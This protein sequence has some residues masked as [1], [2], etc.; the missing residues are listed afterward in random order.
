MRVFSSTYLNKTPNS[1]MVFEGL[2]VFV[3]TVVAGYCLFVFGPLFLGRKSRQNRDTTQDLSIYIIEHQIVLIIGLVILGTL[4]SIYSLTRK[5]KQHIVYVSLDDQF[6]TVKTRKI[7]GTEIKES[8]IPISDFN[9]V[10]NTYRKNLF[11]GNEH[12]Y[13]FYS[14]INFIGHLF[15]SNFLWS[16]QTLKT[17]EMKRILRPYISGG[18]FSKEKEIEFFNR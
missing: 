5:R 14:G 13:D 11:F 9:I 18:K 10:K 16:N 15:F 2:I 3:F 6:I 7:Y 12:S 8:V 17:R 4:L 1:Y